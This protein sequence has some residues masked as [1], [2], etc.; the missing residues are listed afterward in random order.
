MTRRRNRSLLAILLALPLALGLG[1][2]FTPA[3]GQ[4]QGNGPPD[5]NPNPPPGP[6]CDPGPPDDCGPPDPYT[7]QRPDCPRD[8]TLVL[9]IQ[10]GPVGATVRIQASGFN[11]GDPVTG[12]FDGQEMFQ[13]IAGP[14]NAEAA[15]Q[16]VLAALR[17]AALVE[18]LR[19]VLP[20]RTVTAA[21]ATE[22]GAIDETFTVPP[23]SPGE[24][25][26]C[27]SGSGAQACAPFRVTGG[28]AEA[29]RGGSST[30][31]PRSFATTGLNV[32]GVAILAVVL[33]ALGRF[34][35]AGSQRS[36]RS[37]S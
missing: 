1:L 6:P 15:G 23:R 25:Q 17:P 29:S 35:V 5:C 33:L 9:S 30:D 10:I 8:I 19:S 26:V 36:R 31:T 18:A 28:G 24:Y 2:L 12:T 21:Q 4:G 27:V 14:S 32:I 22:T 7:G 34:L 3:T 13:V 11:L 16:P 20:G 37:T